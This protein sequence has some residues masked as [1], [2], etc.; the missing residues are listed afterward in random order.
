MANGGILH[1]DCGACQHLMWVN[2]RAMKG[3][4]ADA[5]NALAKGRCISHIGSMKVSA[6]AHAESVASRRSLP[7]PVRG[8][9]FDMDGTLLDTEAV[10][11][12]TM[13]RAADALGLRFSDEL[14]MSMIGIHRDENQRMLLERFGA[15]FPLER[16]YADSDLLFEAALEEAIPMRPGVEPLLR[17]LADAGIPMAV[18]TS[19]CAPFAGQRLERA[20][21]LRW[22]DVVVTRNDVERPKPDPEPYLLAARL[23]GVAVED[24][25]AVEDSHA[26]VRSAAGAGI[27]TVMVPDLLPPTDAELCLVAAVVPSLDELGALILPKVLSR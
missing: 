25:V 2:R 19:T 14:L 8:V 15:D 20:G 26:G 13:G 9:I 17:A 1:R 3:A 24:A 5:A 27:A 12:L 4:V 18:A 6:F 22:F 11:R 10:H 16:F 7:D 23:L 21:L